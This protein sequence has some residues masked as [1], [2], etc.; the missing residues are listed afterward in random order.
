MSFDA[1]RAQDPAVETLTRALETGRVHHAYRFEGPAGVGKEMAAFALARALVCEEGE[2]LGCGRCGACERAVTLSDEEPHVPL[3]PDVVLIARGLYPPSSLGASHPETVAIGVDQ[4]R[5]IVLARAGYPPHE[6]RALVFI[7]RDADELTVQAAN[8]LLKTLEEP[9]HHT[10]FVLLT[11]RP[12]LLLD[13]VRSRTLP[14]RFGPLPTELLEQ[15]LTERGLPTA[16]A[17]L[18]E[19]SASLA[20]ALADESAMAARDDFA[21]AIL[22]AIDAPDLV[23]AIEAASGT[24]DRAALRAKLQYL[25]HRLARDAREAAQDAPTDALRSARRFQQ[26][27]EAMTAVNANAQAGLA[28]ESLVLRLR[29]T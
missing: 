9:H 10:H 21:S 20:L 8:A 13:T 17:P 25:A 26:V 5:R 19:G 29:R 4:I 15:I 3:H 16:V 7:V 12:S 11:S 1:I 14:V 2:R 27:M 6:G 28:I 23:P 22:D 24:H 18:A